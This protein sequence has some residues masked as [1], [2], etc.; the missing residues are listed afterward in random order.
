MCANREGL[1][2]PLILEKLSLTR[3]LPEGPGTYVFMGEEERVL[4]AGRGD[5]LA[6]EV[7]SFFVSGARRHRG[8]RTAVRLVDR[9]DYEETAT[10]LEAVIREQEL[11]LEHRPPYNPFWTA[12]EGY[13]Y[14]RAGGRGSG[15]SLSATRRCSPLAA[16]CR[17]RPDRLLRVTW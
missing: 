4:L 2:R 1:R 16:R 7:R 6:E 14:I 8:L 5:R 13:V 12:P 11:L 17:C 3:G 15:L 9:I 10:P